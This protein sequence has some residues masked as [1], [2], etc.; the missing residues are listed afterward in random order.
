MNLNEYMEFTRSTAIYPK[1]QAFSYLALGLT[2]EAGEVAGKIKKGIR[3]RG[4]DVMS[5]VDEVGDVFWY[6]ARL[7]DE[8][9]FAPEVVL[10]RNVVKLRDRAA[11]GVI[12]GSGDKR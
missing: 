8:L 4:F 10:D 2:S 5:T 7:C 12:G 11:R 6:L 1:D 3:D 9:G